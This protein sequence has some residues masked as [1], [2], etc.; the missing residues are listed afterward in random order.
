LKAQGFLTKASKLSKFGVQKFVPLA[1]SAAAIA[2]MSAG[3]V[4]AENV[5]D[6]TI[7]SAQ[8]H[9]TYSPSAQIAPR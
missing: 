7:Q 9:S 4:S 3:S 8:A 6:H 5:V 2:M 1:I